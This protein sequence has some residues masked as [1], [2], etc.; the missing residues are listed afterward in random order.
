MSSAPPEVR[1]VIAT[2]PWSRSFDVSVEPPAVSQ[3]LR[4]FRTLAAARDHAEALAQGE[5]WPIHDQTA[6]AGLSA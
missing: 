3:S 6:S 5:G 4:T 2:G 1:V